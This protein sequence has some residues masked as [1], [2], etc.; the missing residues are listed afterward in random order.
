MLS[1]V[2][3]GDKSCASI[4]EAEWGGMSAKHSGKDHDHEGISCFRS[5]QG[6]LRVWVPWKDE[7]HALQRAV[8]I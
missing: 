1:E 4:K 6:K 8:R 7:V 5:S 2:A 3:G